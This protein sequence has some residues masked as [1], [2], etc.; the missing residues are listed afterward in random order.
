MP[1]SMDTTQN[2][3]PSFRGP[4]AIQPHLHGVI[5]SFQ[6]I[7]TVPADQAVGSPRD[8][9][10]DRDSRRDGSAAQGD[11]LH[12][13]AEHLGAPAR[14][15]RREEMKAISGPHALLTAL[16]RQFQAS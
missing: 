13:A 10:A 3:P 11:P 7:D 14:G 16:G 5:V 1:L 2:T 9:R 4:R 8:A 12:R 15:R 6:Q